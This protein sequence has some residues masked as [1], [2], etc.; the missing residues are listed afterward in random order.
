M[1]SLFYFINYKNSLKQWR[2]QFNHF[3]LLISKRGPNSFIQL[4]FK[5]TSSHFTSIWWRSLA[6]VGPPWSANHGIWMCCVCKHAKHVYLQLCG[7]AAEQPEKPPTTLNYNA[8]N[9]W[10]MSRYYADSLHECWIDSIWGWSLRWATW[11]QF[12]I[13]EAVRHRER[14]GQSK[15]QHSLQGTHASWPLTTTAINTFLLYIHTSTLHTCRT[16]IFTL[17]LGLHCRQPK[18]TSLRVFISA[19]SLTKWSYTHKNPS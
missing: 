14:R 3:T 18:R 19:L 9:Q 5:S 7:Y 4:Y 8:S 6:E 2:H 15:P 1:P 16:I 10:S 17:Q 12:I 11:G 13:D